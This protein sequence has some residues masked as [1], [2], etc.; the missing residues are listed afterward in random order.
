MIAERRSEDPYV[1]TIAAWA[2]RKA[3]PGPGTT[4]PQHE[5]TMAEIAAGALEIDVV[6]LPKHV[7]A[8]SRAA[9][10]AGFVRSDNRS[11]QRRLWIRASAPQAPT[12]SLSIN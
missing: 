6:D 8:V 3:R 4:P 9:R 2:D 12:A 11:G 7:K 1:A 10:E 5:F